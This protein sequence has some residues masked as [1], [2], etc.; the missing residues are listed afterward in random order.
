MFRSDRRRIAAGP[1]YPFLGCKKRSFF[2]L[3]HI[4]FQNVSTSAHFFQTGNFRHGSRRP[5][6]PCKKGPFFK[7]RTFFQNCSTF[8]H[9]FSKRKLQERIVAG[10]RC[11]FLPYKKRP[12]FNF[13]AFCAKLFNFSQNDATLYGTEQRVFTVGRAL[14]GSGRTARK[15]AVEH[16]SS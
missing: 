3:S 10:S 16:S 9:F 6:L 2:E 13:R 14:A 15:C 7:F 8:V 1:R 4:F 11:P 12:F 5:F